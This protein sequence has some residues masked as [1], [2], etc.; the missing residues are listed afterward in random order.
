V[1]LNSRLAVDEYQMAGGELLVTKVGSKV[2]SNK[3][4]V[5]KESTRSVLHV[6]TLLGVAWYVRV[7]LHV[8]LDILKRRCLCDLPVDSTDIGT[9]VSQA[10][11][12]LEVF[13][14]SQKVGRVKVPV[15]W[16]LYELKND[17]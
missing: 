8:E 7:V 6:D 10:D 12:N 4:E 1:N 14:A 5:G 2:A 16:L 15:D 9:R 3:G 13:N 17:V 11:I